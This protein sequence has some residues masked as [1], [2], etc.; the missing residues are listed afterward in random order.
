MEEKQLHD[1]IPGI[2]AIFGSQII[3]LYD[4]G[5]LTQEILESMAGPL[6]FSDLE[7]GA[8]PGDLAEDG[9]NVEMIIVKTMD[10]LGYQNVTQNP[11]YSDYLE[12]DPDTLPESDRWD[13][14][15]AACD[16]F[17]KIWRY[18]WDMA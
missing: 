2:E 6:K 9:S 14:N 4:K 16:L 11:V 13:N 18:R 5:L 17:L 1:R 8:L 7:S 10:P 3:N 15:E 12:E